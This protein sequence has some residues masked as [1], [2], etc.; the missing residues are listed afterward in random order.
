M[1]CNGTSV[2]PQYFPRPDV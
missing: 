1:F 2:L